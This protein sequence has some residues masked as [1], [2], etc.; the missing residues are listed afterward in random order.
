M[1]RFLLL[2]FSIVGIEAYFFMHYPKLLLAAIVVVL[3]SAL[4]VVIYLASLFGA[5]E[6]NWQQP[7]QWVALAGLFASGVACFIGRWR[8]VKPSALRPVLDL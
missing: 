7:L 2:V 5:F 8:F 3:I 1:R 6:G 4:Y